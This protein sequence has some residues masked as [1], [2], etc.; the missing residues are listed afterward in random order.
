MDAARINTKAT[1]AV[2]ID[3]IS[4]AHLDMVSPY[5]ALH[6]DPG[7]A[8][9]RRSRHRHGRGIPGEGR[10]PFGLT[11]SWTADGA[12]ARISADRLKGVRSTLSPYVERRGLA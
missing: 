8:G 9:H 2:A 3:R 5:P 7:A 12:Y 1:E 6:L 4:T 11:D 10:T